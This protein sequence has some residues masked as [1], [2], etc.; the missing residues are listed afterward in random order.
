[1]P[2]SSP[3]PTRSPREAAVAALARWLESGLFPSSTMADPSPLALRIV[4]GTLRNFSALEFALGRYC[5]RRPRPPARAALAAGAWQI[6][7]SGDIPPYAA[8]NETVAAARAAR[9]ATPQFVNAVLRAVARDADA[10]RAAI[11]SAPLHIRA[12][13]P[14]ALVERWTQAFGAVTAERVCLA[15]NLEPDTAAAAVPHSDAALA[16]AL[17]SRWRS[18][19][20]PAR[21]VPGVPGAFALPHGVAVPSLPGYGEGLFAIQDP[22]T[23]LSTDMLAPRPGESVLDCCAAPGGKTMQI[24][25]SVGD[26]GGVLA[27]DSSPRRLARL[28]ENASRLRL[29]HRIRTAVCDASSP[30]LAAAAAGTRFDAA[31]ADVPCSNSGV[32]RRRADARWRWSPKETGRLAALQGAILANV[33]SLSPSR[34]VYSTCSIDPE[35]DE[36]VVERFLAS[37]PGRAYSLAAM[38]RRLPDASADGAFAALLRRGAEA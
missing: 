11:S 38:E 34:I 33:A 24:A 2:R 5:R 30:D 16:A 23:L 6:L 19:G 35:E 36:R 31:L 9:A 1:M 18:A 7:L 20:I 22:A 13:H 14:E 3:D 25:A 26:S 28:G 17:L 32:F 10:L 15:D 27:L 8:I 37:P 4:Q 29:A 12:S 21:P